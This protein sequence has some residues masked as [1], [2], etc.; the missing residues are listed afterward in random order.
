LNRWR[1]RKNHTLAV[2]IIG[3]NNKFRFFVK[4]IN[5]FIFNF[6]N[7]PRFE[8]ININ[9]FNKIILF[10]TKYFSINQIINFLFLGYLE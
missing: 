6:I 9:I 4:Y 1:L 3:L 5:C 2:I 8:N 10:K 7:N